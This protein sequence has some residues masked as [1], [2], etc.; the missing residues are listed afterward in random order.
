[1][2]EYAEVER[3]EHHGR[4]VTVLSAIKGEHRSLC[5]CWQGCAK[6]KPGEPDNCPIAQSLYALCVEHGLTTPVGE[7]AEFVR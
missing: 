2:D 3:Y 1:M 4:E 7:C 5:L 6:F